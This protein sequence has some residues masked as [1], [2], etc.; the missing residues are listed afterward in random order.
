MEIYA[1]KISIL[2]KC[3]GINCS[4]TREI[5]HMVDPPDDIEDVCQSST[6]AMM[7]TVCANVMNPIKFRLITFKGPYGN[8]KHGVWSCSCGGVEKRFYPKPIE[9]ACNEMIK[10]AKEGKSFNRNVV[11][12]MAQ[13]Y[14]MVAE[15]GFPWLCPKCKN[16]LVYREE[17][18]RTL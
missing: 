11:S 6:R 12:Q 17:H 3:C 8:K 13:N 14:N 4:G 5:T 18:P 15:N 7:C 2:Y 10:C 9:N 16:K 1:Y